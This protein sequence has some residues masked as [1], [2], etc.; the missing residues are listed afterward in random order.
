MTKRVL[1][2][3][4]LHCGHEYG[5]TPPDW[6]ERDVPDV[7][8]LAKVGRFQRQLWNFFSSWVEKLKPIYMLI[9][10][11]DAI[12]GKG[13]KSGGT[14]LITADRNEQVQIAKTAIDLVDAQKIRLL[15]GTRYHSGTD[16]DWEKGLANVLIGDVE[17]KGHAFLDVNGC[18]LS[19]KHK[20]S[21]SIVP[22]GRMTP[23][24]R[25]RLWNV[26]WNSEWERQPKADI[27]IRSH[28]HY[29]QFCG[30]ENWLAI[31]T[32]A[33]TYNS[34]FGVRECEGVVDV[35]MVYFDFNE[36]GSYK[37]VPILA[38]F[39]SLRVQAEVL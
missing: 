2:I 3:S 25:A 1:V 32:P 37:W 29:F 20:I 39:D 12:E 17:I 27:L 16:E 35:G 6:W 9:V 13:V 15:Y 26:I 36:D 22:H 5:L 34:H 21:K 31:I 23:L 11:G 18:K 33:L 19:V 8:H 28:V 30:R 10:N 14:E 4:D 38:N 7:K 24:A